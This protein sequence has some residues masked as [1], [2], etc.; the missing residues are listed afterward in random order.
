MLNDVIAMFRTGK[1]NDPALKN[2]LELLLYPCLWAI[3][4]HRVAHFLYKLK[5]PFIPRLIS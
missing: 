4:L 1:K 3:L 2:P 5:I